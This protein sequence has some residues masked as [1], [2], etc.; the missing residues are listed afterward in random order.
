MKR[1]L[2][3]PPTYFPVAIDEAKKHL[4]VDYSSDDAYITG[5]IA[6]A[7]DKV[8]GYLRRRLVTQ[9]WKIFLD[10]WPAGDIVLP[11]GKLQSV[12]HVKY[13]DTD[14]TQSTYYSSAETTYMN[15]DIDS[16]PGRIKL[17]YGYSYPTASLSPDNPIEIQFVC[18][19]GDHTP[20]TITAASNATPV[21]LTIATHGRS[22]NDLALVHSVGGNTGA[23]GTWKI[24]APSADTIGLLGSVGNAAYTSGGKLICLQVPEAIRQAIKLTISD[25]FENREDVII[26]M[27]ATVNLKAI[28]SLLFPRILWPEV[29][30]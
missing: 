15:I 10:E 26:G 5:L 28:I 22:A 17:N 6:A 3:T 13:T 29:S 27:T 18:G 19:Y 24:T 30:A 2:V 11:F 1:V 23:N 8:E 12:T 9:T 20:Q 21:V 4:R 16:D 7:T 14:G 25:M